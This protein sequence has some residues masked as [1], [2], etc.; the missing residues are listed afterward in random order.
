MFCTLPCPTGSST[1]PSTAWLAEV[2]GRWP[3]QPLGRQLV[4]LTCGACGPDATV[5]LDPRQTCA[6]DGFLQFVPLDPNVEG[7]EGDLQA[8]VTESARAAVP[9]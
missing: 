2:W 8:I 6:D 1:L 5:A 9:V 4:N 3:V 7:A